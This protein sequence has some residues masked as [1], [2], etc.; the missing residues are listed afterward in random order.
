VCDYLDYEVEEHKYGDDWDIGTMF[1][2]WN[3]VTESSDNFFLDP[4]YQ[5]V[6]NYDL[7]PG[8]G[9]GLGS[10]DTCMRF[11]TCRNHIGW[12]NC[13]LVYD[14]AEAHVNK[15]F[16]ECEKWEIVNGSG[17]YHT[18][19][20]FNFSVSHEMIW[21]GSLSEIGG[22]DDIISWYNSS[23]ASIFCN[24]GWCSRCSIS[25]NSNNMN[26]I[27][28]DWYEWNGMCRRT[29]VC[30]YD[31]SFDTTAWE[32]IA[33][34]P[35]DDIIYEETKPHNIVGGYCTDCGGN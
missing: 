9:D 28:N 2:R 34:D 29:I 17:R 14:E 23:G 12:W 35:C 6:M 31:L 15:L 33:I 13:P 3:P 21:Y 26:V 20:Y 24:T 18:F 30:G 27:I 16:H 4:F 22:F 1:S 5:Y 7:V 8:S 11:K 25:K 10:G 19:H 32:F